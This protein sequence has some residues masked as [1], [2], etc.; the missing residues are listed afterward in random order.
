MDGRR[1]ERSGGTARSS[2]SSS[3]LFELN[4]QNKEQLRFCSFHSDEAR[5]RTSAAADWSGFCC[6]NAPSPARPHDTSTDFLFLDNN[7][8]QARSK[9]LQMWIIY[10]TTQPLQTSSLLCQRRCDRHLQ[11]SFNATVNGLI[12]P[13]KCHR[14]VVAISLNYLI[15]AEEKRK[16]EQL[17]WWLVFFIQR[18][19]FISQHAVVWIPQAKLVCTFFPRTICL[20]NWL[21]RFSRREAMLMRC[22][23]VLKQNAYVFQHTIKPFSRSSTHVQLWNIIS[24]WYLHWSSIP[25]EHDDRLPQTSHIFSL[26]SVMLC[27]ALSIWPSNPAG[28]CKSMQKNPSE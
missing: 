13:Q 6:T 19:C 4:W 28:F 11:L 2:R 14:L 7:R 17:R 26:K 8:N 5:K 3:V 9:M 20:V 12:A 22:T 25:S 27:L 21:W 1:S 15:T 23:G 18:C 24:V 10:P 16:H